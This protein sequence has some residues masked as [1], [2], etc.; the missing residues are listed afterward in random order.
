MSDLRG[1]ESEHITQNKTVRP[2]FRGMG[3]GMGI[4][5]TEDPEYPWE[6]DDEEELDAGEG[7]EEGQIAKGKP[8]PHKPSRAE[9]ELH[10][11]THIPY[12]SWCPHCVR[13]RACNDPHREGS[14]RESEVPVI[15][16]DYMYMHKLRWVHNHRLYA[17][18]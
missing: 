12:R 1:G 3:I 18:A 14:G 6:M 15:S 8:K 17:Y 7:V 4:N 13:G 9:V 10:N 16:I 5:G 11:K 2:S